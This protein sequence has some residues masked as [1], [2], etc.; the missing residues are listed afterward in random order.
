M[1]QVEYDTFVVAHSSTPDVEQYEQTVPQLA[2]DELPIEVPGVTMLSAAWRVESGYTEPERLPADGRWRWWVALDADALDGPPV[3]RR[4]RAGDRFRPAGGRGSR[5]LQD[6]FVDQKVPRSVRGAW[7]VLAT[8]TQ[9]IWIAGLRADS[10][11]QATPATRNRL[12][13]VLRHTLPQETEATL[14]V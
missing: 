8:S 7:P 2:T 4:R 13:V 6:F 1:L 11:F 12:W 10:R 9:I 14:R 5:S 3:L